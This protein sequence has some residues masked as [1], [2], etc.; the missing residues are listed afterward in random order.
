MKNTREIPDKGYERSEILSHMN[1]LK[2][3][4]CNFR[5]G[6]TFG[7][8]YRIKDQHE[9]LMSDVQKEFMEENYLNPMAFKSIQSM[10]SD[11]V[12]MTIKLCKGDNDVS[13]SMTS[14][15]TESIL[16][17]CKA[18]RD[19][20]LQK[21]SRTKPEIILPTTAHV[22]F[23]K[24][25][26]YFGLK[27]KRLQ[28]D[29]NYR[30][31]LSKLSKM[32]NPNTA[33]VVMSAPQY[34]HGVIDPIK[35]ACQI[36]SK[37]NI[38]LHVDACMGGFILPWLEKIGEPIPPWDF[39]VE[40]VTSISLDVHK[41]GYCPKGASLLLFRN[42]S[43]MKHQFFVATDWPGGVYASPTM[44]GSRPGHAIATAYASLLSIGAQGFLEQSKKIAS[45][46]KEF[47]KAVTT[48]PGLSDLE[49]IGQPEVCLLYT[50]PSP[51]DR[52]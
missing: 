20:I 9:Q 36:T 6:K 5:D 45:A 26:A 19:R 34:P 12:A 1:S 29:K 15:G 42:M 44:A 30:A 14:G 10:E 13:G 16:L 24:A 47:Q 46:R 49:I 31:D 18:Y 35:E 37:A 4:D 8:V 22:A 2:T 3:N 38:P 7:L 28:L 17:A 43:Y 21:N 40:G 39:R 33:A 41:Y 32:I 48:R 25:A 27:I 51:R 52:G 23:D 11:V 50:S